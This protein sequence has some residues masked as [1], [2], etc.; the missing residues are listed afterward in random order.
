MAGI[1]AAA[2]SGQQVPEGGVLGNIHTYNTTNDAGFRQFQ[3]NVS[4]GVNG[5]IYFISKALL[6]LALFC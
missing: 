4:A 5:H 1:V 2:P 3:N 6:I